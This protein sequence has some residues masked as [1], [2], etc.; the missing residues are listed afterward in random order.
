MDQEIFGLGKD[1]CD[2]HEGASRCAPKLRVGLRVSLSRTLS[3]VE[4]LLAE[5]RKI[6][7]AGRRETA[8]NAVAAACASSG[9]TSVE[10]SSAGNV[11]KD[12]KIEGEGP[13][14]INLNH[15]SVSSARPRSICPRCGR[16]KTYKQWREGRCFLGTCAKARNRFEQARVMNH[17]QEEA[18]NG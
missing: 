17:E 16:A 8:A 5:A 1:L 13:R 10:K 14:V 4:P 15:P 7:F 11:L 18:S 12:T 6:L 2:P 3:K 9:V